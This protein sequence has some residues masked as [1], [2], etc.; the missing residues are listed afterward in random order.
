LADKENIDEALLNDLLN[1]LVDLRMAHYGLDEEHLSILED[2]LAA[3][4]VI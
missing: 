3:V 4:E 2:I 1:E